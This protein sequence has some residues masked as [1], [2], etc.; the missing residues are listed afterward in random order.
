MEYNEIYA[1]LSD[2]RLK[3]NHDYGDSFGKSFREFGI[4]APVVRMSDKME[5]LKTIIDTVDMVK[6]ETMLDTL[7][8][9]ANYAIMTIHE[10]TISRELNG[11]DDYEG[12]TC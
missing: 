3:K 4:F 2:I 12:Q 6:S 1:M 10:V 5:R 11:S 8:D 7:F 9:L